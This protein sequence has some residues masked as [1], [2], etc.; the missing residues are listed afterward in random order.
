MD[1]SNIDTQEAAWISSRNRVENQVDIILRSPRFSS[2][3][4]FL[5]HGGGAPFEMYCRIM[6]IIFP[7][8]SNAVPNIMNDLK[9]KAANNL[10]AIRTVSE[11]QGLFGVHDRIWDKTYKG[12]SDLIFWM[13][14]SFDLHNIVDFPSNVDR[15]IHQG[16]E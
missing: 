10:K 3:E 14:G 12:T 11:L 9:M 13:N 8:D 7:K 5:V 1:E 15:L 6:E 2:I 4:R 16:E